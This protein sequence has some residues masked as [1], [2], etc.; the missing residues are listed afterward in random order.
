[1][2]GTV[3]GMVMVVWPSVAAMV[4]VSVVGVVWAVRRSGGVGGVGVGAGG[5][6]GDGAL[7]GGCWS[8][9]RSG[10]SVSVTLR[11]PV[12]VPVVGSPTM[13]VVAPGRRGWEVGG[14]G[15]GAAGDDGEGCR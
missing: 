4:K 6:D 13:T 7:G 14:W 9:C 15:G 1:M 2:M 3:T 5:G 8:G 12:M 11:L 10:G